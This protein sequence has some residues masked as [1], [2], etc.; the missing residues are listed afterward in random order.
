[1]ASE[2]IWN[3]EKPRGDIPISRAHHGACEIPGDRLL[4][5]GGTYDSSKRFNDTYLLQVGSM[6]WS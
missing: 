6:T 3:R 5:F 1:M 2:M 4:I